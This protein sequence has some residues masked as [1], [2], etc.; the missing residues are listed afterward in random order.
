[1]PKKV[2]VN[3][4]LVRQQLGLKKVDDLTEN[5]G[6]FEGIKV[7]LNRIYLSRGGATLDLVEKFPYF[8]ELFFHEVEKDAITMTSFFHGRAV[9]SATILSS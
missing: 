5:F 2:P 6:E 9:H 1:M 4:S 7:S 3:D 8:I